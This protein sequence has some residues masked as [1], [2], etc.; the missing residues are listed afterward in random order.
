M[1]GE[2]HFKEIV[3]FLVK[4]ITQIFWTCKNDFEQFS[5][6]LTIVGGGGPKLTLKT[7]ERSPTPL[8]EIQE[9][10]SPRC[11]PVDAHERI[12]IFFGQLWK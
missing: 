9:G 2:S 5:I 4:T 12:I 7:L 10:K 8:F 11:P 6:K 3:L 1:L